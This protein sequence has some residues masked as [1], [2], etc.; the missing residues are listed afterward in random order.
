MAIVLAVLRDTVDAP[1]AARIDDYLINRHH[2]GPDRLKLLPTHGDR[3][4]YTRLVLDRALPTTPSLIKTAYDYFKVR[5]RDNHDSEA[6][7]PARVLE[8]IEQC[9]LVV[10]INLGDADDPYLIFESLNA[11][12]QPLTQADL[13]RNYVLMKFRH[14]LEPGGEQERIYEDCWRPMQDSLG[15]DLTTFLR[16]YRMKEGATVKGA[17]VFRDQGTSR[18]ID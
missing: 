8:T 5:L 7:D 18:R 6:I 11:K 1:L 14:S 2:Q 13:V 9:L 4:V 15:A 17:L 16:H 3:D 12:G 10:M